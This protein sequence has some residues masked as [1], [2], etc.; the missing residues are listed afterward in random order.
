[1]T[2]VPVAGIR[3]GTPDQPAD[4][5]IRNAKLHTNDPR[6]P[7][8]SALAIRDGLIQAVGGDADVVPLVGPGTRVVDALGRRAVP[9]LND[10]HLHVIRGGLNYVLE[11]RWD[12]VPTLRQALAMLRDQAERTPPGQWVRVV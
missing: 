9:G 12:G 11:L 2:T 8:A 6:R 4:L 10:A 5:V 1:M 7:R 3:P